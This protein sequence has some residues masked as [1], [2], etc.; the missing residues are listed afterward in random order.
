LLAILGLV[1]VAY[2][3]STNTTLQLA[4]GEVYRGR[5]LSLYTLLFMGTTPIG[6]AITGFLADNVGVTTTLAIEASICLLATIVGLVYLRWA[7]RK[8]AG[9]AVNLAT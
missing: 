7:R 1:S 3:T 2:S 9:E 6:G 4:S 8:N 5:I